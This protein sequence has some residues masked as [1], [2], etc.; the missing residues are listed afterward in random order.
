M[1]EIVNYYSN[2]AVLEWVAVVASLAYVILASYNNIWCWPAAIISTVLYTVIF[3]EFYLW[4][5]SALQIYYLAMALYGW[6]C[7]RDNSPQLATDTHSVN[8]NTVENQHRHQVTPEVAKAEDIKGT[9]KISTWSIMYHV[10]AILVLT[11]LSFG[12]GYLMATYTPT[13]FPYL[14]ACTTV[15]AVFATYLVTQKILENWL[16]WI[17]IDFVSIYLYVE[18]AL[19]PTAFLFSLFVIIAF[20]GYFKWSKILNQNNKTL[21]TKTA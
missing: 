1:N 4:S 16:Y 7:W 9:L 20:F 21:I 2:I 18:K 17:V 8:N 10:K 5:D 15:F 12:L 6:Y 3:Y 13:D 14:D 11:L 19:L